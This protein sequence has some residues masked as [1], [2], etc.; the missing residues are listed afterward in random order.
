M[1]EFPIYV[2]GDAD[3]YFHIFN[4][5][6]ILL[7]E[8]YVKIVT[9]VALMILV[10]RSGVNY[11]RAD[12]QGGTGSLILGIGIF[13]AA[14]YPTTT[15]HVIDVR[16]HGVAQTY[17]KIDNTPFALTFLAYSASATTVAL[18]D[19]FT[20]AFS[21]AGTNNGSQIG[22]GRQPE[23]IKDLIKLSSLDTQ[24]TNYA[25]TFYKRAFKIYTKEC[26]MSTSYM[27]EAGLD[28][29]TKANRNLFTHLHPD[30]L[31]I[32]AGALLASTFSDG[33]VV[34][35]K[36]RD[37]FSYIED[38]R[39]SIETQL[40]NKLKAANPNLDWNTYSESI[41]EGIYKAG[42]RVQDYT[43]EAGTYSST[44]RASMIN[45]ALSGALQES[46]NNY[47]Y[48]LEGI[49]DLAVYNT[50]KN[51]IQMESDGVA[52]LAWV[53]EIAPL[54]IHYSLLFAYGLFLLMV[55][56]ALGMGYENSKKI[57][58]NYG[59]GI[60][61]IHFGY[62]AAIIANSIA[63]FYSNE[64]A[65]ELLLS[66]G[67]NMTA[68]S[69]ISQYNL[70]ASKMEAVS[71]ILLLSAYTIGSGIAFK[72]ETAAL[73]GAIS[74]I[75][76]RFRNNMELAAQ[77]LSRKQA[78]DTMEEQQ[79]LDAQRFIKE[80]GFAPAPAG[81]G[82]VKY[83]NDLKRSLDEIGAAYGAY[84]ARN[85]SD[86]FDG[87]YLS[88]TANKTAQMSAS[89][90]TYGANTTTSEAIDSGVVMGQQSAGSTKAMSHM[91]KD[92]GG[93]TLQDTSRIST[94]SQ[95]KEQVASMSVAKEHFGENLDG[96]SKGMT[97]N[98]MARNDADMKLAG[99]VGNAKGYSEID[100]A[101]DKTAQNAEYGVKS[102]TATTQKAIF[103]KGGS[104]D[105]AVAVD[106]TGAEIKAGK[107]KGTIERQA[108]MLEEA[109]ESGV[110]KG[111]KSLAEAMSKISATTTSSQFGKE[112]GLAK[113]LN[114]GN[115][116]ELHDELLEAKDA[117]GQKLYTEDDLKDMY[118]KN[119]KIKTG[120]DAAQWIA[121]KQAGHMQSMHA[122]SIDGKSVGLSLGDDNVRV[123]S[124]DSGQSINTGT[125]KDSSNVMTSGNKEEYYNDQIKIHNT[126]PLTT[127][128]T[129]RF[130]GDMEKAANWA[131]SADAAKWMMDPRNELSVLAAEAGYRLGDELSG[132]SKEDA[133]MVVSGIMGGTIGLGAL[134]KM[135]G[136]KV[137]GML[138]S[139][140]NKGKELFGKPLNNT[141]DSTINE[142]TKDQNSEN[143]DH[144]SNHD[145]SFKGI[146]NY[147]KKIAENETLMKKEGENLS[148]LKGQ[149]SKI[150]EQLREIN[151]Q[152]LGEEFNDSPKGQERFE[153][154][155]SR[156]NDLLSNMS[157][158]GTKI[159]TSESKMAEYA[160]DLDEL[161]TGK[162]K[163]EGDLLSDSDNSRDKKSSFSTKGGLAGFFVAAGHSFAMNNW[164]VGKTV[165]QIGDEMKA[166]FN[167]FSGDAKKDGYWTATFNQ[168]GDA[169]MGEDTRMKVRAMESRGDNT[170]AFITAAAGTVD[171]VVQTGAQIGNM[172][173]S[174]VHSTLSPNTSYSQAFAANSQQIAAIP[175]LAD[176]VATSSISSSAATA[177]QQNSMVG[178]A[179]NAQLETGRIEAQQATQEQNVANNEMANQA[180]KTSSLLESIDKTLKEKSE[181]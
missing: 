90:A 131:R 68:V 5:I 13:A 78:Y 160:T 85:D 122:L 129:Q 69:S 127:L 109:I 125:K 82:E 4:S 16:K 157:T 162:R 103:G 76:G 67:N 145:N 9:S 158:L 61:A 84:Q 37:L 149:R 172:S 161:E 92:V 137:S 55:P 77:D 95:L 65:T 117:K 143:D 100:N 102:K 52:N 179:A 154:L 48:E 126:D 58:S 163:L 169:F 86:T 20:D 180:E 164:D 60:V 39:T 140:A 57:L 119:G 15:A 115:M 156:K 141:T 83:V 138:K 3:A 66:I 116:T 146:D 22:I 170:G 155:S 111:A 159:R 176:A 59:M 64:G 26:A 120:A 112:V 98:Q 17:A 124:I 136:G 75:G 73:N 56:V 53:N 63:L 142:S 167:Q 40:F 71:G 46:I 18:A 21:V 81:V 128:A 94:L 51:M 175:S 121:E 114:E 74:T 8:N 110:T 144:P 181:I 123:A 107:E 72:G 7:Q 147:N 88:G 97:Y 106:E 104:V 27:P 177:L 19:I 62:V 150:A 130:D 178:N 23:L 10:V 99:R 31:G 166:T 49:G 79:K 133:A 28:Y 89:T 171:N 12:V 38:K 134:D 132:M 43:E 30:E 42:F 32:P 174:A 80:N 45:Y 113:K 50:N 152:M 91:L 41:A 118:D 148:G 93:D 135:S 168:L 54:V 6:A 151:D 173:A 35:D 24:E 34:I 101:Y 2:L 14:L 70:Y 44:L 153:K 25:M 108:K 33:T 1:T 87:D 29:F 36:C 139:S 165:D 11:S 105:E 47:R 96:T